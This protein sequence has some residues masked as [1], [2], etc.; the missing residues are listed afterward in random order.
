VATIDRPGDYWFSIETETWSDSVL[1]RLPRAVG[2]RNTF[3][4]VI[5]NDGELHLIVYFEE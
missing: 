4:D 3:V 5:R 2:D 1:A